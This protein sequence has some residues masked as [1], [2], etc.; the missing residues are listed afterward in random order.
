MNNNISGGITYIFTRATAEISASHCRKMTIDHVFL[1]LLKLAE[2]P[3][4][5]HADLSS[6]PSKEE[7]EAAKEF[8]LLHMIDTAEERRRIR[9]TLR[10][11][12]D[13]EM[14]NDSDDEP[15]DEESEH[16]LASLV[17]LMFSHGASEKQKVTVMTLLEYLPKCPSD[18]I[19]PLLYPGTSRDEI[20]TAEFAHDIKENLRSINALVD[21][22]RE[23]RQSLLGKVFGQEK[24]VYSFCDGIFAS[25]LRGGA[26]KERKG[27]RAV[28]VFAGPPGIGKTYLAEECAAEMELP[29]MKFDMSGF[30]DKEAHM[31]LIGYSKEYQHAHPGALTKFTDE[32][33]DCILIFDEIEKAH[34]NTINLF[35]Q[36]LDSGKLQD[37]YLVKNVDFRNTII[38]FTTNAGHPLYEKD[39]RVSSSYSRQEIISA[40]EADVD[41]KTGAHYF[42]PE[43]CS[44]LASGWL[45]MFNKLTAKDLKKVSEHELNR[46]AR[47]IRKKY[48]LDVTY[49]ED[50]P[51]V[52]M[53]EAG[54]LSDARQVRSYT[55]SFCDTEFH[56]LWRNLNA[57]KQAGIDNI[58]SIR[59]HVETERIGDEL[60]KLFTAPQDPTVLF[61]GKEANAEA[62]RNDLPEWKIICVGDS[63]ETV[64]ALCINDPLFIIADLTDPSIDA[65]DVLRRYINELSNRMVQIPVLP[66]IAGENS[67]N[68][69][70]KSSLVKLGCS[71]PYLLK[72]AEKGIFTESCKRFAAEC[73]S[74][75]CF[76]T[77]IRQHKI[78]QCKKDYAV[79]GT[80]AV[81]TVIP[82]KTDRFVKAD[83]IDNVVVN[84]DENPVRFKDVIGVEDAV[85]EMRSII[86][87]IK[88]PIRY[89]AKG[90]VAP[91][92]VLLYGDPGTGKTLLAKA[93]AGESGAAFLPVTASNFV[94]LYQGSGPAA[95]R[96]LFARARSYAPSVIFIDEIDSIGQQRG[97]LNR[98]AEDMTLNS[99]LTE[100]DGFDIDPKYPVIV[101]AATNYSPD[102][103]YEGVGKLDEALSRRFDRR[104]HLDLPDQKNRNKFLHYA[105]DKIPDHRVSED[106]IRHLSTRASGASLAIL[107]SIVNFA[108]RLA[109]KRD[110]CLSDGFLAE[111]FEEISYGSKKAWGENT[112]KRIAIHEAGHVLLSSLSGVIP[113]HVSIVSRGK[114][115]GYTQC[116]EDEQKGIF[117]I[118]E[119][120][121]RLITVLG[122]RAAELVY[123][124]AKEGLSTGPVDDLKKATEIARS[125][126]CS[127]G[128]DNTFGLAVFDNKQCPDERT[129]RKINEL[130]KK[131]LEKAISMI[132]ENRDQ[133]EILVSELL[134]K[135]DLS[136]P[137]IRALLNRAV[138]SSG[139]HMLR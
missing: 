95:V 52:M 11:N 41:K 17:G 123:Y 18:I 68:E 59:F 107:S 57:R 75:D 90:M 135:N 89:L 105:I 126:I 21:K 69:E 13:S 14:F 43:I 109:E 26:D 33:P 27:P 115:G 99:L 94:S 19:F 66:M 134:Q 40:L 102:E 82:E 48:L 4:D 31:N 28:F 51:F 113:E 78:L 136:G 85:E 10:I 12:A 87:Y 54:C 49:S 23:M 46:F 72:D 34:S 96:E 108:N 2:L 63:S 112:M 120:Q 73:F 132:E 36:I 9:E 61:F 30:S 71:E 100:M 130:L 65:A 103:A 7:I 50:L 22:I 139:N 98:N 42:P 6:Y 67:L 3:F 138:D 101:L 62:L 15:D 121:G 122:G 44:R 124:G 29:I 129:V 53:T 80:E 127:F 81:I 106:M 119:L 16:L 64:Q 32:H 110:S 56:S 79:H 58:K 104:I 77:L 118:S 1:G 88:K 97:R 70:E 25:E 47:S 60:K 76:S 37:D 86:E 84:A 91:K 117:T 74:N 116:A 137:E 114:Q 125:M 39:H 8:F 45:I 38:V 24:A 5:E 55:E 92:G 133:F 35:L 111:A 93:L 128:M 83:D 20:E 131:Y